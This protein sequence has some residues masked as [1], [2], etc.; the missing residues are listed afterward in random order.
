[1]F[2]EILV[3]FLPSQTQYTFARSIFTPA[4]KIPLSNGAEAWY[5]YYQSF[6]P[7]KG[8]PFQTQAA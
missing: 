3:R 1:M 4:D 8:K 7:A 6:R 5:G 2:L